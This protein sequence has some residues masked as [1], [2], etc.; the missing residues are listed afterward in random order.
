MP[1]KALAPAAIH[2]PTDRS[3]EHT[4]KIE[5][6]KKIHHL[7]P[8]LLVEAISFRRLR[9][10]VPTIAFVS[11]RVDHGLVD[12][13]SLVAG[14][15]ADAIFGAPAERERI[16]MRCRAAGR[17]LSGGRAGGGPLA[18]LVRASRVGDGPV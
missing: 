12:G 17:G 8:L 13:G 14:G 5:R 11:R 3:S 4:K 10:K 1:W 18:W 7:L 15:G 9:P 16:P 2:Q 6:K